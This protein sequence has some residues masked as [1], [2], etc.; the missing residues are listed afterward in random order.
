MDMKTLRVSTL[1]L[2][3]IIV[4]LAAKAQ[5]FSGTW[6]GSL[7][8]TQNQGVFMP[9]TLTFG[10]SG[11]RVTGTLLIENNGVNE[12]YIVEG[13]V[14]DNQAAGAVSYPTDG[15]TFQFEGVIQNSQLILVIGL[16]GLPVLT[17]TFSQPGSAP[18][19]N[20]TETKSP[21]YSKAAPANAD[22]L[23][24]NQR[25]A[26]SWVYTRRYSSG[27]FYGST[28]TILIFYPDGRLGSGST[29]NAS[30][31][32]NSVNS[33]SDGIDIMQGV[34]WYSKG[35]QIWLRQPGKGAASDQLFS[36]F[37][38]ATDGQKIMLYRNGGKQLYERLN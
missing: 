22:G 37:G 26:G 18:V 17:G 38:M 27:E 10:L 9:A 32:S 36:E 25:L 20:Q 24:R 16:L 34:R 15:S 3:G 11:R 31:G 19:F 5:T 28:R 1:I 33:S 35:E 8:S 21:L 13:T 2:I 6:R 23:P 12:K 29:G 30:L 4:Q 14:Q 7:G